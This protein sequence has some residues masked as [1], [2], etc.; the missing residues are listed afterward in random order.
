MDIFN[1]GLPYKRYEESDFDMLAEWGFTFVRLPLSYQFWA[2]GDPTTWLRIDP[3]AIED[4]VA[5][6]IRLGAERGIHVC[7]N[8]HRAPG[9]CVNSPAEPLDLWTDDVALEACAFHWA[10]FAERFADVPP[11]QLSFNLLNEPGDV[12]AEAYDR[13]HR[14]LVGA[15]REIDPDRPIICDARGWGN[16]PVPIDYGPDV[17]LSARGYTPRELSSWNA[18]WLDERWPVPTWPLQKYENDQLVTVDKEYLR[19]KDVEPFEAVQRAGTGVHVGEFG[20][21]RGAP[22]DVSLRWTEDYLSLWKGAGFGWAMWGMY[23]DFGILDSERTDVAYENFRG[24]KL[25]RR[26]LELMRSYL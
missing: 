3:F 4:N 19:R 20:V 26:L 7:L 13:V 11:A 15:I 25:D 24:H 10:Y 9:Y 14:R 5:R 22:H 12:T 16:D 8:F 17:A 21:Y 18:P 2:S 23:G 1:A 6:A